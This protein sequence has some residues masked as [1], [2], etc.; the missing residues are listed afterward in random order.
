MHFCIH[1]TRGVGNAT[2]DSPCAPARSSS[3]R[4][5]ASSHEQTGDTR[6]CA[7]CYTG[8]HDVLVL[9]TG[10]ATAEEVSV[11]PHWLIY[12]ALGGLYDRMKAFEDP[13]DAL[14]REI[15]RIR[16][17]DGADVVE[18]GCGTGYLTRKLARTARSVRAYDSSGHMLRVARRLCVRTGVGNC[19]FAAADHRSI[20]LGNSVADIVVGAWTILSLVV[21]AW[22]NDWRGELDRCVAEARRLLR[23][24]GAV[25]VVETANLCGELPDGQIWHPKRRDFLAYLEDH[26][27]FRKTY[28][29]REWRYQSVRQAARLT[30]LFHGKWVARTIRRSKVAAVTESVGI[31]SWSS[32]STDRT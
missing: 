29:R 23:S 7:T 6:A 15:G 31:W 16:S 24:G 8:G 9:D 12:G 11:L 30:S 1:F 27:G 18:L 25:M 5:R 17:V 14:M 2:G 3:R 19:T 32:P 26:H 10:T 21:A 28:F 20:P 22:E 4:W 13:E